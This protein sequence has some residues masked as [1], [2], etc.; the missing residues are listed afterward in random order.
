MTLDDRLLNNG[1][2]VQCDKCQQEIDL[3][4]ICGH[5]IFTCGDCCNCKD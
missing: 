2:P 5:C 3:G 4:N 1:K